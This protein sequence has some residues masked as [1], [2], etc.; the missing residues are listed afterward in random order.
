MLHHKLADGSEKDEFGATPVH[1][2]AEQNQMESI[3]VF[4]M[5]STDLHPVDE[6][7]CTPKL[8][9]VQLYHQQ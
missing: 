1:D 8:V 9:A 4:Q 6:D 2:A 3:R 5:H 7:G